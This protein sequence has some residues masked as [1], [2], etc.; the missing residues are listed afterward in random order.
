MT[1]AQAENS[2]GGTRARPEMRESVTS[3]GEGGKRAA[4]GSGRIGLT[5][6]VDVLIRGILGIREDNL[7]HSLSIFILGRGRVVRRGRW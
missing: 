3:D 6:N 4:P 1:S 5:L 7:R 2:R